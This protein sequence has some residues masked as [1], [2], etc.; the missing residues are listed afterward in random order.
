MTSCR[1]KIR[2]HGMLYTILIVQ[3]SSEE[4]TGCFKFGLKC[5]AKLKRK[6]HWMVM[7]ASESPF[8]GHL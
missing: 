4:E 3:R 2:R 8:S 1:Y 5:N 6:T 7:V